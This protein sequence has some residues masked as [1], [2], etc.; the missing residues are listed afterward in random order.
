MKIIIRFEGDLGAICAQMWSDLSGKDN[1]MTTKE[2][3][4]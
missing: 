3:T 2:L 1:K 4:E